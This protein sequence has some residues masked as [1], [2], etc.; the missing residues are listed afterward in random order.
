MFSQALLY[1]GSDY[2]DT[3]EGG[4]S[5][6]KPGLRTSSG[7]APTASAPSKYRA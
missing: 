1:N 7:V 4:L 2:F 5:R 3:M 6:L